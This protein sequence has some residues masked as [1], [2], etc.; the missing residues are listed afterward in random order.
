MIIVKTVGGLGNQLFQYAA[1]LQMAQKCHDE[2]R[3]DLEHQKGCRRR[4][5]LRNLGLRTKL[6]SEDEKRQFNY[7]IKNFLMRL[8]IEK[9]A[10]TKFDNKLVRYLFGVMG[11]FYCTTQNPNIPRSVYRCK[12]ILIAG[13]FANEKFWEDVISELSGNIWESIVKVQREKSE[14]LVC[15]HI[16][17]GDYI[18]NPIHEV[19][20]DRYYYQAM[21]I[22]HEKIPTCKFVVFTDDVQYVKQNMYF[23][24][25]YIICEEKNTCRTLGYMMQCDHYILSNSTFSW[26]AQRLNLRED[27]VVIAPARWFNTS[28]KFDLYCDKWIKIQESR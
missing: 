8:Y 13:L 22:A 2:I 27:K 21:D 9:I 4:Y 25:E 7:S 20:N 23:K 12:N 1:G 14:E 17:R 18:G 16:R 24:Y 10:Y 6:L 5:Q 28:K 26:W 3:I 19:C 11:V 15:V